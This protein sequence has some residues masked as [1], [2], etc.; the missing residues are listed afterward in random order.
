MALTMCPTGLSSPVD[1]DRQDFTIYSG[2][3]AMGRVYEQRGRPA[4]HLRQA[5]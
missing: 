5:R 2:G 1:K 3:W 4:R